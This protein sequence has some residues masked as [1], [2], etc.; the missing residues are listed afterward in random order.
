MNILCSR[1][2]EFPKEQRQDNIEK[3]GIA[4]RGYMTAIWKCMAKEEK[5]KR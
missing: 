3:W 5:K 2:G 1:G 4:N